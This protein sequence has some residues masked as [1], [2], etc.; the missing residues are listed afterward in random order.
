ML[1]FRVTYVVLMVMAMYLVKILLSKLNMDDEPVLLRN[2]NPKHIVPSFVVPN[3]IVI[4]H[5]F[6]FAWFPPFKYVYAFKKTKAKR[7]YDKTE[8]DSNQLMLPQQR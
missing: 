2:K 4:W 8:N 6:N 7:K 1:V 5:Q 3:K